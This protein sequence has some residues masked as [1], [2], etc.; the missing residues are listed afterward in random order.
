MAP[1]RVPSLLALEI[2]TA[3]WSA[4][5]T[6]GIR[7]LIRD[8]SVANPLWGAPRIH[9]EL[10]KLGIDVGQTTVAKYMARRRQPPSQG[11]KTF[12]R[13]HADGIASMDLFVVP[14]ISF[15]LLYGFLILRH[16]RRELLWLGVTA[17]PSAEWVARQL[18]EAYGWQ[19]APRYIIRDRDCIYGAVLTRRLRAMGIRDRPIAPRS[20]WQNGCA[21]RLIGSIGGIALTMSLC[22]A[23]SIS[24]I[25]SNRTKNITTKLA[26]TCHCTRTRRSR[27][28][29]RPSVRRW[30][31]P[32]W[33]GCTINIYEYEF[34]TGTGI[35]RAPNVM[36]VHPSV[37][38]DTVP[39]FITY[40][41][42]NPG[43]INMA[44]SGT[45]TSIHMSGELFKLMAGV[46]MQHVPD[47]DSAPML[48]DLLAG[49]V[50]VAFD[51]LQPSIPHIKAG[52][53]RALAV[54]TATRSEALPDL[55]M[56][57]DFVKGYEASTWN[58]V[59]APKNTPADIDCRPA[60]AR[61]IAPSCRGIQ[62]RPI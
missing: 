44:S 41:K 39:Q 47:R 46:N 38:A 7:R 58:G 61:E 59:C 20:P 43:K 56:V 4:D 26:R 36:V 62:R 48:T 3:R 8:M 21:E 27:A 31:C 23:S 52:K 1:R 25:C 37:P 32:S 14:T 12:L 53:L 54:T 50:Q 29:C 42:D 2:S 49:Q 10:L 33:V 11:W 35:S 34:P 19:Q 5:D 16:G 6:A 24:A 18:A 28:L 15:R 30:P 45:G 22:L 13:N 55:P 17:H 57:G 60:L 51:N 40:A 9:G